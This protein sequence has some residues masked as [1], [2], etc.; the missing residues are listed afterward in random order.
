MSN[1]VGDRLSVRAVCV[2]GDQ[3]AFNVLWFN[4]SAKTA[5]GADNFEIATGLSQTLSSLYRAVMSDNA[6]FNGMGVRNDSDKS[7]EEFAS[8]GSGPGTAVGDLLP[9]QVS[10]LIGTRTIFA[11]RRARGR[12][13]IP[14]PAEADSEATGKPAVA[15]VTRLQALADRLRDVFVITGLG[16]TLDLKLCVYS[17]VFGTLVDVTNATARP[18]WATQRR[19]GDYGR[20]NPPPV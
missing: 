13:Y 20:T 1:D 14:F 12:I 16:G 4:I 7:V 10:G 2:A 17:R 19:R 5:L 3:T 9:R 18:R 11:L 6:S 15:Y 8:T